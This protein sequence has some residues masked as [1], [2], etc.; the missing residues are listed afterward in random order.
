M[1]N[2]A[3]ST[4]IEVKVIVRQADTHS[5][6]NKTIASTTRCEASIFANLDAV[7]MEVTRLCDEATGAIARQL[8]IEGEKQ[9]AML[10]L[11]KPAESAPEDVPL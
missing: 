6:E 8:R 2:N 10:G 5:W 3:K 11:G 9:V 1:N 4:E 7:G